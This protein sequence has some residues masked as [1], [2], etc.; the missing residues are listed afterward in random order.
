MLAGS[1]LLVTGCSYCADDEA[2]AI[3]FYR[4]DADFFDTLFLGQ[5]RNFLHAWR[6][7]S[8]QKL[9]SGTWTLRCEIALRGYSGPYAQPSSDGTTLFHCYPENPF[10]P[11]RLVLFGP[12]SY[13]RV[14]RPIDWLNVV[15]DIL[16]PQ[17]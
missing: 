13:H 4:N 10:I 12:A 3:G 2:L 9:E 14:P 8:V 16:S 11:T 5:D 7:G 1:P 15:R 17:S 6:D